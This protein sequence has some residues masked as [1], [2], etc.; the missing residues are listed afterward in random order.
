[1]A[2]Y[3]HWRI[4]NILRTEPS[5]QKVSSSQLQFLNAGVNK[6]T[7]PQKAFSS[8]FEP[9]F[10]PSSAFEPS[11]SVARNKAQSFAVG[12]DYS[13]GYSFSAPTEINAVGYKK[14]VIAGQVSD[15]WVRAI[16]EGSDNLTN[17]SVVGEV[18]FSDS[19]DLQICSI[20][21]VTK[22]ENAHRYWRVTN[23]IIRKSSPQ[24][25][26]Y[27][28]I[29]KLD[30]LNSEGIPSL[31]SHSGSAPNW[32]QNSDK[33]W[34]HPRNAFTGLVKN[35]LP[36]AG[37]NT[38]FEGT[39][40][41][42]VHP[43]TPQPPN[44]EWWIAYDFKYAVTVTGL[45]VMMRPDLTNSIEND[46][47]SIE[48]QYS[49]DG[50][51]W[52]TYGFAAYDFPSSRNYRYPNWERSPI[53]ESRLP[54]TSLARV[55]TLKRESLTITRNTTRPSLPQYWSLKA[56]EEVVLN[57]YTFPSVLKNSIPTHLEGLGQFGY[58]SGVVYERLTSSSPKLPVQRQV[59]LF[60]QG[61]GRLISKVWSTTSGRYLFKN[62]EIGS[63][64]M[65]VAVDHTG[66]FNLEGGAF[67][68]AKRSVYDGVSIQYP[69]DQ[70]VL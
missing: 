3:R 36:E 8:N 68:Q 64:Y 43:M 70:P 19:E 21:P 27:F 13:I 23:A 52:G 4:S 12:L 37:I 57:P 33:A 51:V 34:E 45:R 63:V 9:A 48:V 35:N 29:W 10:P 49:D 39:L 17:W 41:G 28:P 61:S 6:A 55:V 44:S 59:Y 56:E 65:I 38:F 67:K 53:W 2:T 54:Y 40:I 60:H 25:T 18:S 14:G 5:L 30:F 7:D 20:T 50:V 42:G 46:W 11:N 26:N 31:N 58:I 24:V 22:K 66:K 15:I 16:V 69:I 1:M 47:Q 62:L 32:Y